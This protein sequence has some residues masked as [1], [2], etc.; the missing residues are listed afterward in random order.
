MTNKVDVGGVLSKVFAIYSDQAAV[1][2]PVAF[3]LFLI[4]GIL[5]GLLGGVLILLATLVSLVASTLYTGMVV[6]LV[7]DVQDGRRDHSAGDL[8]SSAA[9]VV[10]PLIGAG[11]LVGLIVVVGFILII[12]PG[13]FFLTI[14]AVVGP[15][16]VIERA[17]VFQS[18][19]RSREL[20]K[21]NGWP[22]FGVI[23]VA[24]L[25]SF[26]VSAILGGIGAAVGGTAARI[27]L[28]VLANTITAPIAALVAGVLYFT[29]RGAPGP[30]G[31]AAV[32][33]ATPAGT[34]PPP[35]PPQQ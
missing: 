29:L 6:K 28:S 31:D 14:F 30:T 19:G 27:I 20:V 35:P 9:P 8:L 4:V 5:Q 34:P 13:L 23:I 15:V 1:L 12:V 10:A 32:T 11:L 26:V 3:G 33:P 24:F 22:V 16:I 25:I 17:G 2:L 7:E 21:G 18:L